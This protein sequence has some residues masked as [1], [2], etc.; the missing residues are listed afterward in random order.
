MASWSPVLNLY[1]TATL[2]VTGQLRSTNVVTLTAITTAGGTQTAQTL[3]PTQG[4]YFFIEADPISSPAIITF[5]LI[6]PDVGQKI[7]IV[8]KS[9]N[10]SALTTTLQ[11]S[12]SFKVTTTIPIVTALKTII[13]TFVCVDGTNMLQVSEPLM[14]S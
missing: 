8:A 4:V 2:A 6:N 14:L 13:I 5:Q 12:S 7:T 3:N 11:F 9:S 1:P 10:Q